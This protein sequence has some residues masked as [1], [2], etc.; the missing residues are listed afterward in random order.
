M[1]IVERRELAGKSWCIQYWEEEILYK[2]VTILYKMAAARGNANFKTGVSVDSK[3]N[4]TNFYHLSNLGH[5]GSFLLEPIKG[6]TLI[7]HAPVLTSRRENN[8]VEFR[9][10]NCHF[11]FATI[12]FRPAKGTPKSA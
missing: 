2:M 5:E 4:P 7:N 10:H 1:N 8:S 12:F 9:I 11:W 6:E 3:Y